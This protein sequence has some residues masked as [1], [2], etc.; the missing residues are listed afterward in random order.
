ERAPPTACSGGRCRRWWPLG[1]TAAWSPVRPPS[2]GRVRVRCGRD[3][4]AAG[5]V[6]PPPTA[7]Y[8]AV[9]GALTHCTDRRTGHNGPRSSRSSRFVG[10][11]GSGAGPLPVP[12]RRSRRRRG[13]ASLAR[14]DSPCPLHRELAAGAIWLAVPAQLRKNDR[15]KVAWACAPNGGGHGPA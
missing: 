12:L 11:G 9:A 15:R 1:S 6:V 13:G 3:L 10:G 5:A 4:G 7:P 2:D 14:A 8:R